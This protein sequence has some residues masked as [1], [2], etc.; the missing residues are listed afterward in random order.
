M[1]FFTLNATRVCCQFSL[2]LFQAKRCQRLSEVSTILG[3]WKS[4]NATRAFCQFCLALFQANWVGK[5][6]MIKRIETS[7][8]MTTTTKRYTFVISVS[9]KQKDFSQTIFCEKNFLVVKNISGIS[10]G[11]LFTFF[12][13]YREFG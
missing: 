3:C 11:K 4:S 6:T 7:T 9:E 2:A 12:F 1:F 5:V 10:F 13:F 8:T